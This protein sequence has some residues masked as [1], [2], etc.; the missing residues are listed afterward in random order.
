M[1]AISI[2]FKKKLETLKIIP[3]NHFATLNKLKLGFQTLDQEG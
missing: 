3:L 2:V 1:W